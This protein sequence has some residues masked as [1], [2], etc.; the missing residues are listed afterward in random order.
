[1]AGG[2]ISP[3]QKMI[4]MMYLVLTALLALNVSAEILKAFAMINISLDNTNNAVQSKNDELYAFLEKKYADEPAKTE[5]AFKTAEQLKKETAEIMGLIARMKAKLIDEAGNK[6]GKLDSLDYK[7]DDNGLR[8]IIEAGNI[9]HASRL[10][11]K[12]AAPVRYGDSLANGLIEG[13]AKL[14]AFVPAEDSNQVRF[15]LTSPAVYKN[16][17]GEE[18]IKPWLVSSF[19]GMPVAGAVTVLTKLESDVKNTEAEILNYI[20]KSIDA[21]TIKVTDVVA[22]VIAPTSYVLV[23]QQYKADILLAAYDSRQEPDIVLGGSRVPV[24]GGLG[25]YTAAATA[26]GIKKYNG[27]IQIMGPDGKP[28]QYPFEGEYQ[29]AK[30]AVVVSPDKMNVFYIGVDNPVSISAP[31][32]PAEKVKATISSGSLSGANGKYVVKVTAPGKVS[33]NVSG[34]VD[35]KPFVLGA[36][37]FRVKFVPDPTASA[38]GLEPGQVPTSQMR[39]QA[40]LIAMLKDFDFDLRF[41]ITKFRM[42]YQQPR[43]DPVVKMNT[44]P[45]FSGEINNIIRGAKPGDRFI[46]DEIEARGPDGQPRK[47]KPITYGLN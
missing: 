8:E 22:K 44:G 41:D 1:M 28:T 27:Y 29:V 24:E 40:G 35:G 20:V 34:E 16:A 4:N 36:S 10:F 32:I 30:P 19:Y 15:F 17:K 46:F 2:N 5:K 26:E 45:V 13:L 21:N 31:G 38:G 7:V 12:E 11:T 47:L 33:I 25:K 43:Q 14:K 3:R 42:I 18:G 37:E 39:G 6:D 9:D 23:G